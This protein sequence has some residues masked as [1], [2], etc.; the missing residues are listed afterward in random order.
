MIGEHV[1]R[2]ARF[3]AAHAVVK[4]RDP[5]RAAL[6]AALDP[7]LTA[8]LEA[9]ITALQS[10]LKAKCARCSLELPLGALDLSVRTMNAIEGESIRTIGDLC[11]W[12][13]SRLLKLRNFGHVYL[14]EI[15]TKLKGF[16]LELMDEAPG[17]EV[18]T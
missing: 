4:G 8:K 3:A 15:Q 11:A 1:L 10:Q 17:E 2:V 9:E 14:K 13:P 5:I 18:T 12:T 7:A 6:D 16:A